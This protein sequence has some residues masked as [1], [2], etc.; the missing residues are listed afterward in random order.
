MARKV[1]SNLVSGI[2]PS[3]TEETSFLANSLKRKG[4]DIIS[5]AQGEPDFDTPDYIKKAAI[6]AIDEGFTKYT[7]VPG[8]WELREAVVEKLK[9]RNNLDYDVNE[10]LVGNGGKQLLYEAFATLCD[11]GDEV[12]I[13]T[14][15]YVS[16]VDQI[17]LTGARPVFMPTREENKFRPC[18]EEVKKVWNPKVK[19]FVLNSPCNPTGAVFEEKEMRK[20]M[21]FLIARGTFVVTDEVYE[22][23]LY[24]GTEHTS[25]ASLDKKYRPWCVLVNSVSKTYAMT[26]WRVGYAAGP[27]EI[28]KGMNSLQGHLTG[29]VNS[30]AQKAVVEALSGPQND[31]DFMVEK[32]AERKDYIVSRINSI[33]GLSCV[34]PDGAFYIFANVKKMFGKCFQ[35]EKI[36]N[37]RDVAKFFLNAAHVAVVPGVAF[38]Y[39][40][41]VRFVF[42]KSLETIREGLDRIEEAMFH[43]E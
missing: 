17:R 30:I 2:K 35:G 3:P 18:L 43:L 41:Y 39:E 7:D 36:E 42:A 1:L 5:F 31:I 11:P 9:R 12:I 26:G 22:Y 33:E 6:K 4:I 20:I 38:G 32:Y 14:P 25:P 27:K 24:N 29:N 10:I 13:P 37:D 8:I 19:V 21:D 15:C 28:I 34:N 23:L 40:G 16:Y